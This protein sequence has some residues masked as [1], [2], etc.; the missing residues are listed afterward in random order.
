M[1]GV[2]LKMILGLETGLL[3]RKGAEWA[4]QTSPPPQEGLV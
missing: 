3:G 1:E 4:A 2:N